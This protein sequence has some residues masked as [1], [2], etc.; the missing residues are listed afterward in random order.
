MEVFFFFFFKQKTAYEIRK[1]DWSSDVCSSDL[2]QP[3]SVSVAADP[4]I[5]YR[6]AGTETAP[7]GAAP[8]C[9]CRQIRLERDSTRIV[10]TILGLAALS[11]SST[12]IT[13]PLCNEML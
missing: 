12:R 8:R 10:S 11:T 9:R 7:D 2:S 4:E 5:A 13:F 1:G 6:S 3:R